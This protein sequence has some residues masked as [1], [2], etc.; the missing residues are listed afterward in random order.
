MDIH[1]NQWKAQKNHDGGPEVDDN[2][3]KPMQIDVYENQWGKEDPW[4]FT[5][6]SN[7]SWENSRVAHGRVSPA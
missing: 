7:K 4:K 6:W 1:E 2:R 3:W 5:E